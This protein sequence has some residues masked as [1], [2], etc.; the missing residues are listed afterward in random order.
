MLVEKEFRFNNNN[1]TRISYNEEKQ[2]KL[3]FLYAS[4][5][6]EKCAVEVYGLDKNY[7]YAYIGVPFSF[8][9]IMKKRLFELF[10]SSYNIE[11][12]RKTP[13]R[14]KQMKEIKKEVCRFFEE[15]INK[16]NW[17]YSIGL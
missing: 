12:L 8:P 7:L 2:I 13:K 1:C 3:Y 15:S 14:E 17:L 4:F 11:M 16:M 10:E 9:I 6:F 5:P